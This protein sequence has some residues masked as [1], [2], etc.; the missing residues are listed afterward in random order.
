[1]KVKVFWLSM[2]S[3]FAMLVASAAE[4]EVSLPAIISDNMVIQQ[5]FRAPIWGRAD[6]G[7][8]V[9]VSIAG[10][11]QAAVADAQGKWS[12]RLDAMRPGGPYEMTVAGKNTITVRNVMAGE[13]WLCSGQSN[14]Q[15]VVAD[16]QNARQEIAQA[17]YPEIRTFNVTRNTA[18][19]PQAECQGRWIV[20]SPQTLGG[21]FSAVAY[22]FA[23][24]LHQ[25]LGMP[26]GLIN[27]SWGG[28]DIQL[29]MDRAALASD[30]DLRATVERADK[31]LSDY[32]NDFLAVEAPRVR[33]WE[34]KADEAKAEGK[35]VPLPPT[36]PADPRVLRRD[37]GPTLATSLYNAMIA[38]L[39]PYGI[40]G[41]IWYQ[42]EANAGE[43]F[44]YRKLFPA[45]INGWRRAWGEGEFPF[46]FVQLANYTHSPP[47]PADSEW[48]ELRE[49]QLMALSLPDT[50][51]AVTVDIGDPDDIHP[52]NKQ[53]VGRRLALAARAL[54]YGERITY[55][56]PTYDG[57]AIE[58][59]QIRLRFKHVG[60]GLIA[61]G[62][63]KLEGFAI[64]GE[65]RAFV[66]ADAN[67]Q[68]D[69]VV[70]SSSYVPKPVAVRYAWAN[71]PP[72]NL[73][74][75]EGLPASPFRTDNWPGLTVDR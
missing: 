66:W 49:A 56:G 5:A 53:E 45:M 19:E 16:G 60:G 64:A 51:M 27:S 59:Q 28:T 39:I 73:Y 26:V 75:K 72:S 14:M 68:G 3:L 63:E 55:S 67:I 17:S 9:T 65:D 57:M 43:A 33:E 54:V 2:L 50:G 25:R 12:L 47:E 7:E 6:P 61:S 8:A 29:W 21:N 24:D 34:A 30:P 74:N 46:F 13:V 10:Q 40:R 18:I 38:P 44:R 58:G 20:C 42:G 23:R 36:L 52:R 35:A 69:T 22:F 48:A 62:S 31:V 15:F 70:V 32:A 71:D 1:V 4:A 37:V 11:H 41:A